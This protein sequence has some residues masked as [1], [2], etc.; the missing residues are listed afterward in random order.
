[1][2]F[3]FQ[4]SPSEIEGKHLDTPTKE[5]TKRAALS[6]SFADQSTTFETGTKETREFTESFTP[7]PESSSFNTLHMVT[8]NH[9]E[10]HLETETPLSIT[11]VTVPFEKRAFP[12]DSTLTPETESTS[13]VSELSDNRRCSSLYRSF[14]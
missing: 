11:T 7:E 4:S 12:K 8:R 9:V 2:H 10:G 5:G 1:M 14:V 3:P 13:T 6:D